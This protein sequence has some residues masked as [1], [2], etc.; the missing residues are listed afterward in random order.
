VCLVSANKFVPRTIGKITKSTPF[1]GILSYGIFYSDHG[2]LEILPKKWFARACR[3]AFN[4]F[5]LR[6]SLFFIF[7]K[8][9][10]KLQVCTSAK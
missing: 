10:I 7:V 5:A 2:V 9:E 4:V 1:N 6:I 3:M 8:N